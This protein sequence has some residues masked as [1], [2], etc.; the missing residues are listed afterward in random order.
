MAK[1]KHKSIKLQ[2]TVK[3]TSLLGKKVLS[4]G[5][6]KLGNVA[7][8][9]LHPKNWNVEGVR[10]GLSAFLGDYIGKNYIKSISQY[11]VILKQM[12]ITNYV[13]MNVYDNRG[14]LVGRARKVERSKKTNHANAI[15]VSTGMG[16]KDITIKNADIEKVGRSVML[17]KKI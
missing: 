11:G 16:K 12:P 6:K 10:L 1:I 3:L 9:H 5:G 13:G 14:K 7:D 17:N 2:N 8:V 4:P 15:I